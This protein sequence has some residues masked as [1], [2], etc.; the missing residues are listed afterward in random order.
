MI[1]QGPQRV[2]RYSVMPH[3][4]MKNA[5]Y[6]FNNTQAAGRLTDQGFYNMSR[7]KSPSPPN[8]KSMFMRKD[9]NTSGKK[10]GAFFRQPE[11][12]CTQVNLEYNKMQTLPV[13]PGSELESMKGRERH[14][15]KSRFSNDYRVIINR[16]APL[17]AQMTNILAQQRGSTAAQSP[18]ARNLTL[19][20]K[21]GKALLH[22]KVKIHGMIK[23]ENAALTTGPASQTQAIQ[24]LTNRSKTPG[25]P[26]A[27]LRSSIG[28]DNLEPPIFGST[29]GY[30][31][32]N[33]RTTLAQSPIIQGIES[34]EATLNP[35]PPGS[36]FVVNSLSTPGAVSGLTN[37]QG[38]IMSALMGA[39]PKQLNNLKN[40]RKKQLRGIQKAQ[41]MVKKQQ[42]PLDQWN[43]RHIVNNS[44]ILDHDLFAQ[45]H[46]MYQS[47]GNSSATTSKRRQPNLFVPHVAIHAI[48]DLSNF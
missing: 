1:S 15:N 13:E 34:F 6:C 33:N 11:I 30:V 12:E 36:P 41:S 46:P 16:Q 8:K 14:S 19:I 39:N 31:S 42:K 18:V 29:F 32:R 17:D 2:D 27:S 26:R 10:G 43:Y 20:E 45:Q 3:T 48:S 24:N 9:G 47:F 23:R 38:Q 35:G 21:H 44:T 5:S 4:A 40:Q 28:D 25:S 22:D 37:P 7:K